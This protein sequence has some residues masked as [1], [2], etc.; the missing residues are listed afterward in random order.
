MPKSLLENNEI[1]S[2]FSVFDITV[3]HQNMYL[4]KP[5]KYLWKFCTPKYSSKFHI[6]NF[7]TWLLY[8]VILNSRFPVTEKIC[9]LYTGKKFDFSSRFFVSRQHNLELKS[10]KF[11]AYIKKNYFWKITTVSFQPIRTGKM[12]IE[13]HVFSDHIRNPLKYR[14]KWKTH[15]MHDK[16]AQVYQG[17]S[18]NILFPRKECHEKYYRIIFILQ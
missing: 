17:C 13:K 2:N 11:F 7:L 14:Y 12:V 9:V 5:T 10:N 8:I 15:L 1:F 16:E 6:D 3:I 4:S 18:W